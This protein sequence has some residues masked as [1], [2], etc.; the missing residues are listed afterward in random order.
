MDLFK[1]RILVVATKHR[2]EK[3]IGPIFSKEL[4]VK[5]VLD[6]ELNTDLLGT[7][8]GEVERTLS[9]IAAAKLKCQM[10]MDTTGC[11][12]AIASEGSFAPDPAIPL[13]SVNEEYL[14]FVDRKH[15]LELYVREITHNTNFNA[16]DITTEQELMDFLLLVNFPSHALILRKCKDDH[17]EV[18][19]GIQEKDELIRFFNQFIVRHGT[20]YV[21]T[22]MRALYNPTRMATIENL[23]RKLVK[24]IKSCCPRCDK[25]GFDVKDIIKG[26]PC[27]ECGMPTR[28]TL[29]HIYTCEYCNC[30]KEHAYPHGHEFESPQYCDRCNP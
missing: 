11:D 14:V 8:S 29:I 26:L 5:C 6:E 13:L 9:P 23:T 17:S 30:S 16:A 20:C 27:S 22:D 15:G 12:L 25:P 3:V 1:D 24:K 19:K 2:K 10:A 21:E 4:Q 18:V 28:S 7:F